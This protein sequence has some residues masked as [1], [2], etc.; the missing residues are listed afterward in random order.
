[1]MTGRR[2]GRRQQGV[3]R[4]PPVKKEE[5]EPSVIRKTNGNLIGAQLLLLS[6]YIYYGNNGYEIS[7]GLTRSSTFFFFFF[8]PIKWRRTRSALIVIVKGNQSS[9]EHGHFLNLDWHA[10]PRLFWNIRPLCIPNFYSN[11][12]GEEYKVSS[13]F[14]VSFV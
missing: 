8:F 4:H 11:G 7:G 14:P 2:I 10:V 3:V 9:A 6:Q 12:G 13:E 1:M 5:R